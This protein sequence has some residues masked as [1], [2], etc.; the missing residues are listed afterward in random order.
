MISIGYKTIKTTNGLIKSALKSTCCTN[1]NFNVLKTRWK[2][3]NISIYVF[4]PTLK[5]HLL[6]HRHQF[7]VSFVHKFC[8]KV[9]FNLC[10]QLVRA[11]ETDY[12]KFSSSHARVFIVAEKRIENWIFVTWQCQN[13]SS[14]I[15]KQSIENLERILSWHLESNHPSHKGTYH[16]REKLP[17]DSHS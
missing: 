10:H 8:G 13:K 2:N 5:K 1:D 9:I 3:F 14:Y 17:K 16:P 4:S 12:G 6:S 11:M 15:R 7:F